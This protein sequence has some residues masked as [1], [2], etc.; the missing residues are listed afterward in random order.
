M[1]GRLIWWCREY[2]QSENGS[3]LPDSTNLEQLHRKLM[4]GTTSTDI[5]EVKVAGHDF[6]Y[7]WRMLVTEAATDLRE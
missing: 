5:G 3:S 7:T 4:S 2:I 1:R 6:Y